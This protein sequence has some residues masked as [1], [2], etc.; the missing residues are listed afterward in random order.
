M[1]CKIG[2]RTGIFHKGESVIEDGRFTAGY[3]DLFYLLPTGKLHDLLDDRAVVVIDSCCCTV[4]HCKLTGDR[5]VTDCIYFRR[6]AQNAADNAHKA[7]RADTDNAHTV[8]ELHISK[9]DSVKA[10]GYH[11][12]DKSGG[13]KRNTV[14][15][16]CHIK[17]NIGDL[18]ILGKHTIPLG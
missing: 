18:E 8:S 4:L 1:P 13:L 16:L 14:W 7:D 15:D 5:T 3:D 17:V 11:I 10:C 2:N 6:A 12:A 9:L